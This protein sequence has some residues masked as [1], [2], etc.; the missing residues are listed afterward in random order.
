MNEILPKFFALVLFLAILI[1]IWTTPKSK[2]NIDSTF[3]LKDL[4]IWASF[5]LLIQGILYLI[6]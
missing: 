5:L 4:R 6:F 3:L 2:L 1:F